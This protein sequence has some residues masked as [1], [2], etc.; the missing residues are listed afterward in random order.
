M[1][2]T[3]AHCGGRLM[4][5]FEGEE[6]TCL[7]CGRSP[8][9]PVRPRGPQVKRC[10][11]GHQMMPD[12][13]YCP[14]CSANKHKAAKVVKRGEAPAIFPTRRALRSVRTTERGSEE[15]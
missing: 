4:R 15:R 7:M 6:L 12:V 10:S 2:V 3:C 5:G 9:D 1:L 13:P 11:R 8:G 14:T